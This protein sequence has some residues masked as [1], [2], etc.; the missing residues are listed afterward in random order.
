MKILYFKTFSDNNYELQHQNSFYL[1]KKQQQQ[2][3]L[4]FFKIGFGWPAVRQYSF[5][6]INLTISRVVAGII[7]LCKYVIFFLKSKTRKTHINLVA[8]ELHKNI[9][10]S[11]STINYS[12]TKKCRKTVKCPIMFVWIV[13]Y[14]DLFLVNS[15]HVCIFI[16]TQ[17]NPL[18]TRVLKIPR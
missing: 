13:N 6:S 3:S 10:M 4:E 8:D 14:T 7:L 17:T 9:I 2:N 18:D 12:V 16:K 11:H 5:G 15:I 1:K